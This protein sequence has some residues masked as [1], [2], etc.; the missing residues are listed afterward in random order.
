[1]VNADASRVVY[2]DMDDPGINL[3]LDTRSDLA[4]AGLPLPPKI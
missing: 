1:M 2:V 4:R 3:D